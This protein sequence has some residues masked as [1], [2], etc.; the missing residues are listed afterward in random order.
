MES[1][2]LTEFDAMQKCHVEIPKNI[3]N[4]MIENESSRLLIPLSSQMYS[5]ISLKTVVT[6]FTPHSPSTVYGETKAKCHNLVRAYR[7]KYNIYVACAIL[8]N[9]T[10]TR[11]KKN[12]VFPI[13]ADLLAEVALGRQD[14]VHMR[15]FEAKIDISSAFE[16]CQGMFGSLELNKCEDFIFSSEKALLLR[17]I[18]TH[19]AKM[20][21]LDMNLELI[22]TNPNFDSQI[23]VGDCSKAARLLS[24]SAKTS[25]SEI[26]FEMTMSRIKEL[27]NV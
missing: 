8:F 24:W 9:H 16:V 10:S 20:L 3:M 21:K 23:L 12:F 15:N 18:V 19:T 1:L 22:S 11:S 17:D 4:W 25:P 5:P 7:N 6:E 13:L 27:E 2:G 26:L 14:S